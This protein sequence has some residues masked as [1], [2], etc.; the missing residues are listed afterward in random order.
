MFILT[1]SGVLSDELAHITNGLSVL[2]QMS[3]RMDL[4]TD[5]RL[6]EEFVA[7]GRA[8]RR[9]LRAV[10]RRLEAD[11]LLRSLSCTFHGEKFADALFRPFSATSGDR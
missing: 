6:Y 1:A 9:V 5:G 4:H 10:Q 7:M 2:R 11:P 8:Q 3:Q